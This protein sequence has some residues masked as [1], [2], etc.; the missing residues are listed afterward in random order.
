MLLWIAWPILIHFITRRIPARLFLEI[1]VFL[2]FSFF[3][4][5]LVIILILV[6]LASRWRAGF[7]TPTGTWSPEAGIGRSVVTP[8]LSL[9][10]FV[11]LS[12]LHSNLFIRYL[13]IS[14]LS[15]LLESKRLWGD[16]KILAGKVKAGNMCGENL[17]R[18]SDKQFTLPRRCKIYFSKS[19][20]GV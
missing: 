3:F 10:L 12:L 11:W 1:T 5:P 17:W 18:D 15:M 7:R 13:S 14:E 20:D 8:L 16:D 9:L 2:F 4:P 6:P 19:P